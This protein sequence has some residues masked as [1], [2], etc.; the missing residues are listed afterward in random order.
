MSSTSYLGYQ[1]PDGIF[2]SQWLETKT[3]DKKI[4]YFPFKTI[5][6]QFGNL[7]QVLVSQQ[8]VLHTSHRFVFWPI[9]LR[10]GSP[11]DL[12]LF[13]EVLPKFLFLL[14]YKNSAQTLIMAFNRVL[15]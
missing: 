9:F 15:K 2:R 7:F 10:Q 12:K 14:L 13:S 6:N 3:V 4:K 8:K 11:E 5:L 1:K